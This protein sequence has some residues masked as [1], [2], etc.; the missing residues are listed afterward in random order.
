MKITNN[1]LIEL[2]ANY[3]A[4]TNQEL[5]IDDLTWDV[6]RLDRS[7]TGNAQPNPTLLY[8]RNSRE[9]MKQLPLIALPVKQLAQ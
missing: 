5:P 9:R 6:G 3:F 7:N 4:A 1:I 2:P 8:L